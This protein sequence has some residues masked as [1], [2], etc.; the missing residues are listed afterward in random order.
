ME[1]KGS[2]IRTG[3]E[4]A[5]KIV[6][7]ATIAILGFFVSTVLSLDKNYGIMSKT[8]ESGFAT[9]VDTLRRIE[10]KQDE[11]SL[12]IVNHEARL[13][14][15]EGNRF[16]DEDARELL[17]SFAESVQGMDSKIQELWK[18]IGDIKEKIPFDIVLRLEKD[19]RVMQEQN[20]KI[21]D[22]ISDHERDHP[23]K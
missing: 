10:K 5:T 22:R 18:S 9:Q 3:V 23:T 13:S 21:R 1:S 2:Q 14:T 17:M 8:V 12:L 15:M 16:T 20:D 4:V 6:T 7:W 19:V 11:N